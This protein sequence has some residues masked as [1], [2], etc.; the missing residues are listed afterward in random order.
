M[1]LQQA[2]DTTA[3]ARYLQQ[4]LPG[5]SEPLQVQ[6]F[7]GGQS[8][9]TYLLKTAQRD[10]VMRSKPAPAAKLLPSAHAIEREF[11]VMA[12]LSLT[13]VPVPQMMHFCQDESVI[14][15][16]FY[17]MSHVR[18]R[19]FWDPVL[20]GMAPSERAAIYDAM[21]AS[22]AAL[23]G[24]DPDQV[25]L[26]Q[27]GKAGNYFSRQIARWSQQYQASVTEPIQEMDRLIE[28][29]PTQIPFSA[30]QESKPRI[31]HG[32]FRMD[33]LIFHP[34]Q[35]K[36]VAI[37]DWELSTLGHPLADLGYHCMAWHIDPQDFRGMGGVDI[38][39]LGIPA[40]REYIESYLQRTSG[41]STKQLDKDWDFYLAYNLFRMAA[42]LQGI[43][44]RVQ[45]GVAASEQ[46]QKLAAGARPLAKM[47]WRFAQQHQ[48]CA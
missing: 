18:G 11:Q 2:L 17:I 42:I 1:S 19:V 31:V 14:G 8:N 43:A 10:F 3:L 16:A 38:A 30:Q 23:H 27:Y 28:C 13:Q 7:E 34:T 5:F 26:S 12:A 45:Q 32:D 46:S 47:A 33:N 15:R 40:E 6:R 41:V 22:L 20:P 4:V 39:A 9:P 29:L 35:P 24:V 48:K 36:V 21:N 25:G 37:L 44:K